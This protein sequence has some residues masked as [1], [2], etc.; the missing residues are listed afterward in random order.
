MIEYLEYEEENKFE[1]SGYTDNVGSE[2]S[3]QVLSESRAIAVVNYLVE[4]GIAPE[5]LVA[6]GYGE[7]NPIAD[8][9]TEEGRAKNRRTEIKKID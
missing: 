8:N 4:H 2:N 3:N 7:L 5:R 6:K 9:T 1:I